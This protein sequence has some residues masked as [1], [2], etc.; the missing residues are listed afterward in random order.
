MQEQIHLENIMT[1][2]VTILGDEHIKAASVPDMVARMEKSE[3]TIVIHITDGVW[4]L[5][6]MK[7]SNTVQ[8]LIGILHI[9]CSHFSNLANGTV[10]P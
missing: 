10:K 2:N 8:S 1:D 4:T 6:H 5:Q 3:M 7:G 9:M